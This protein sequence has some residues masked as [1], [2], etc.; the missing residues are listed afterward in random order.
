MEEKGVNLG[1][2]GR[3]QGYLEEEK[4]NSNAWGRI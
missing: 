4:S 1:E 3:C 2:R